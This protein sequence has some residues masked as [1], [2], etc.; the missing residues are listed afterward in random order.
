MT[1]GSSFVD[2]ETCLGPGL[3]VLL[4]PEEEEEGIPPALISF[5]VSADREEEPPEEEEDDDEDD[6]DFAAALSKAFCR[7]R[8][9]S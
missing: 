3:P 8:A 7:S 1:L 9:A 6:L 5:E 2:F 4:P